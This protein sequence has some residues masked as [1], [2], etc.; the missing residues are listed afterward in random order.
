M[1]GKKAKL[2]RKIS[3]S[4]VKHYNNPENIPVEALEKLTYKKLK[5]ANK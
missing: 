5:E 2:L 4:M 1:R 3:K